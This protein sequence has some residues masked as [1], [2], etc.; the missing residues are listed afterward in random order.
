M[1]EAILNSSALQGALATIAVS[2]IGWLIARVAHAKHIADLAILAYKYAEKEGLLQGIQ[3]YDKLSLFM[4]NFVERYKAAH[5]GKDPSPQDKAEAV[6]AAEV[7]VRA[8]DH[9]GK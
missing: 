3:G 1:L 9:L 4:E 6:K 7:Q 2:L 5:G 8:E